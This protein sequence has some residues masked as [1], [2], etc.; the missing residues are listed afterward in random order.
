M[1]TIKGNIIGMFSDIHI[2][3]SQDSPMWHEE[4]LKIAKW[5]ADT[6]QQKGINDIIIPGD[7]FH[8]RSEISVNTISTAK[9]FFEILKDFRI[10]ISTGNHDCYYKDRSDINSISIFD[11]WN[12]IIVVDKAPLVLKHK[13]KTIS[14]IPWGVDIEDIPTSD[15]CFGHFEI[16]TFYMN[17]FKTCSHGVESKNI[18]KKAPFIISGHF[19]NRDEREYKN[20]KILY[21][22]SPYQQNFG[23]VDQSRGIYTLNLEDNSTVFIENTF[24]PKYKKILLSEIKNKIN[25]ISEIKSEIHKNIV[26]LIVDEDTNAEEIDIITSKIQA[27]TPSLYRLD[28]KHSELEN[29]ETSDSNSYD[30]LNIEETISDYVEN[31][32]MENKVD[33]IDYLLKTYKTILT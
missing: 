19:H 2:G 6:F 32:D 14:L 31:T 15:I 13:N 27:L 21:L 20:G 10:F 18:L 26:S 3:I 25:D 7:I 29:V 9:V 30:I 28:Y 24:T 4:I 33:I 1:Y 22:G 16:Q 23:D 17:T 5:I 12:N 11:G 8:N